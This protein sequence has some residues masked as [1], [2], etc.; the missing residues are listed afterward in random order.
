[1][2]LN[3][4]Q[5]RRV[6]LALLLIL[7]AA[8][9]TL[10]QQPGRC[11][12]VTLLQV[13]DVY[14]FMPVERGTR[15][16]LARVSTLRK[17]IMKNSPHTLFLLAGDTIS[18]SVETNQ[19]KGQQMID[20]WNAI[21]LD[22]A[23][24]GNHE[25]D[26]GPDVLRDRMKESRFV[27]LTA[28]V[29]DKK[30][31]KP[32]NNMPR[33]VIRE[34]DGVKVGL[35]GLLLPETMQTSRPGPDVDI[36]EPYEVAAGLVKEMRAQGA[37]VI[38]AVTHLAMN[39][40]K[41]LARR[42]PGIDVIIGG[43]EHTLLQSLSARTPIFKMTADARELGRIDLNIDAASGKLESIDWEIIPVTDQVA[44]DPQFASVTTKY[45]EALATYSVRVGRTSVKLDAGS[46]ANRTRETNIGNFI[47]DAFRQQLD[48]DVALINGGSIRADTIFSPGELSL[49]DV[50][51]IL[52]FKS[53]V[54]KLEVT[55]ATLRQALEHGVSQ[56]AESRE[57]G[58]FPQV[59]GL[60]FSF[61]ASRPV[62]SR[63]QRVTVNGQPLNDSKTYTLATT[64]YLS[65]GGDDYRMFQGARN[66]LD[67]ET[68]LLDSDILRKAI[69]AVN[70]IAPTTD[71]RIERLDKPAEKQR[72]CNVGA[73]GE[74]K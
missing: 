64:A 28:N 33:Y 69:A 24:L 9:A 63:V 8:I 35:F 67:A 44:D 13:N 60:R 37:H 17:E 30:T 42:V 47:A 68:K 53:E 32:F 50:L 26:M 39:Q 51:S 3:H 43:H 29:I 15:G 61:D 2:S 10:A 57:P 12:R 66:L 62:G 72:T 73:A 23:V 5:P 6:T 65:N 38:V 19:F 4:C 7:L 1:M 27:W 14:H 34:F 49:H 74:G 54:M 56:S 59:S 40:D 58:R 31:N 52:P 11:V 21:G 45:K 46:E 25:F 22:Y 70:T 71:G 18:P 41:L 55:G 48:A 16:G 36:Q 20:A